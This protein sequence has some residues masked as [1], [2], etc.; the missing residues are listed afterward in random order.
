VRITMREYRF[1][2]D[3]QIPRGRVVFRVDN[4]G[5]IE[6]ALTL[7]GLADD[8]P[9]LDEQLRSENRRGAPTFARVPSRPPGVRTKFAVDLAPGRY[10][11][12]CFVVDPDGVMHGIKGM[13]AEFRVL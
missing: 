12:I 1:D 11:L 7:I 5:S 3:P 13:A 9:P 8:V 6:H 2:F 10:G 4:A